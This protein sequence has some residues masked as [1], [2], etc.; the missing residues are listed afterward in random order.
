MKNSIE[1]AKRHLLGF[2]VID[3]D[4]RDD[5]FI[6]LLAREDYT[7]H[8]TWRD[9]KD[10]PS[11]GRLSKRAISINL[12]NEVDHKW[13]S[14]NLKGLQRAMCAM[15]FAPDRKLL[16]IDTAS[17][18]WA[19]HHATDGFESPIKSKSDGG[20]RAG[21]IRRAKGFGAEVLCS[22]GGRGL[23][24]R[25]GIG[26]WRRVGNELPYTYVAGTSVDFG[27]E[28]F[29]AFS[30]SNLYAVG[31]AGDIW[32]F[33][34]S[35]W[36]Q[37][38]FPTNWGLSAVCCGGDGQV[39]VCAGAGSVYRGS[40]DRWKLIHQGDYTLPFKDMVWYEGKVWCT[41]DY[42]LWTIEGDTL[43]EAD[44]PSDV[45]ICSGNL[46]TRDGVL[47]VAGYGGAAFKRD[48]KWTVIFHDH[49][50]REL[51]AKSK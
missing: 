49:A 46:A 51:A 41:S 39:Y 19:H 26:S 33:D 3:C 37:C 14:M 47:L 30:P 48:G 42:G 29:D 9:T 24:L 44:V 45:K 7:Q 22:S 25:E 1:F 50:L 21:G 38:A 40:G 8:P 27:F 20:I 32:H 15:A 2:N 23:Y 13:G 11:E 31:G 35:T 12:S 36:R 43:T 4:I 5:S 18:A 17:T 16:V 34:G 28:D 6:Y 10:P